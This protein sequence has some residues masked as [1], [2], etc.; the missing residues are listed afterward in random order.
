MVKFKYGLSRECGN[1]DFDNCLR[2]M[3]DVGEMKAVIEVS[4]F[5][6]LMAAGVE[7]EVPWSARA[8]CNRVVKNWRASR[9]CGKEAAGDRGAIC[10]GKGEC[11]CLW[12]G[13]NSKQ[14]VYVPP[15]AER[16]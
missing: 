5:S 10:G 7:G 13:R 16:A 12:G 1:G 3:A 8:E 14:A 2:V 4:S 6:V 15:W 11:E 9:A